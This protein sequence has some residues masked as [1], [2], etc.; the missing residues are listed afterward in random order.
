MTEMP[1]M[2]AAKIEMRKQRPKLLLKK[3]F[4]EELTPEEEIFC[5]EYL[6]HG[7]ATQA[8][9][10]AGYTG[11]NPSV[12]GSN[13]LH[14]PRVQKKLSRLKTRDE[15]E[16]DMTR[17]IYLK[18]LKDT[19]EKAMADGDY[20]GANKA[21]ELIGKHL[22]YLVDQKAVFTATKKLDDGEKGQME[23]EVQRLAKIA[24]VTLG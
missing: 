2:K 24:G 15:M 9:K 21:M 1:D 7:N 3:R 10:A 23:A 20:G 12:I 16:A 14:K 6:E 13:W 22:G 4:R 11:R 19:Y 18:M 17:D 8:V 5:R